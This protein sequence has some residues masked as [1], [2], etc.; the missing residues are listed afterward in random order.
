MKRKDIKQAVKEY[1]FTNPTAKLRV[2]EIERTLKLPLPSVIRYCREL[3]KEEILNIAKI[4]SV[5]FYTANRGSQ[6]YL[7]EKQLYNIKQ[8]HESGL[9]E[10][11]KVE[12]SNPAIVLFGSYAKGEDTEE[13]D[14]DLYIETPS[15]RNVNLEKFEKVLKREIQLFQYKNLKEIRN[16]NLVNNIING[17]TLNNYIEVFT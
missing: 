17:I 6:K 9:I 12:L 15:N 14:I 1:F 13:S 8:L 7:L 11:V 2:R 5:S 4:G 10:Y 3:E 16:T